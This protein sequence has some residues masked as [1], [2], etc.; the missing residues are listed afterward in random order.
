MMVN[1]RRTARQARWL[2]A[3]GALSMIAAACA[4]NPAAP[5][6]QAPPSADA[7]ASQILTAVEL[8]ALL[9]ADDVFLV[10]VHVPYQGEIPGTDANIAFDQVQEQLS[11]FPQDRSAPIVVYCRSG[12]MS[13]TAAQS[14]VQEGYRQVYDLS[15]GYRAWIAEGYQFL[16]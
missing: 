7:S 1:L 16:D 10:N 8:H 9:Q 6:E 15:G 4:A 12:S 2:L 3:V 11:A 5:E 13:E 14:L